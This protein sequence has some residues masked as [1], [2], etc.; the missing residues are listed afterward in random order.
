MFKCCVDGAEIWT[1]W[2]DSHPPNV[3]TPQQIYQNLQQ[4]I[5]EGEEFEEPKCCDGPCD[6]SCDPEEEEQ[7]LMKTN[8]YQF[9]W[10]ALTADQ[11]A[12]LL[13][14]RQP[15]I[16]TVGSASWPQCQSSITTTGQLQRRLRS[17]FLPAASAHQTDRQLQQAC[18]LLLCGPW[19]EFAMS[20]TNCGHTRRKHDDKPHKHPKIILFKN[21]SSHVDFLSL[22]LMFPNKSVF[23][24]P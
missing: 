16:R 23:S 5:E 15:T 4:Q 8:N 20:N 13:V 21:V 19:L 18:D 11:S 24:A 22:P 10:K 14:T 9:C 7:P 1:C 3:L 6:Q 2:Y 12:N 17:Y